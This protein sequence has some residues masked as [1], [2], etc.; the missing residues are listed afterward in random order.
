MQ[1]MQSEEDAKWLHQE[2]EN[3]VCVA[4]MCLKLNWIT[5]ST[6][7]CFAVT[8]LWNTSRQCVQYTVVRVT[9]QGSGKWQFWGVRTP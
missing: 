1:K 9:Q 8:N 4:T 2:E 6:V 7:L 3:L 5:D